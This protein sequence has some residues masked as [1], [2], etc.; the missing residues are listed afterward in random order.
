MFVLSRSLKT[1]FGAPRE[2]RVNEKFL[3]LVFRDIGRGTKLEQRIMSVYY[4]KV[5]ENG[6]KNSGGHMKIHFSSYFY[7]YY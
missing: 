4:M 6:A 1:L 7:Y 2:E 3:T 5:V